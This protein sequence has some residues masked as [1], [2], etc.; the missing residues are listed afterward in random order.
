MRRL[1]W[2][3]FGP[4]FRPPL[5]ASGSCR[6]PALQAAFD[7]LYPPGDQW[8]W[9]A[10]FVGTIPA[11]AVEAHLDFAR[12]LPTWKSTMHLYPI[13]GAAGRV[14]ADATPWTYR[15]ARFAQVIVGVDPDPA[16]AGTLRDWTVGYWDALH[17]YSLGGAYTNFMM[18]EGADRVRASYGAQLQAPRQDQGAL[19]PDATSSTSTRTFSR[20]ASEIGPNRPF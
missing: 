2:H 18:D 3:R 8:Y 16:M 19:R 13:D 15:D 4:S 12:K 17:P 9:R 1:P 5:T 11:K 6:F 10:D 20:R 14:A 7:G